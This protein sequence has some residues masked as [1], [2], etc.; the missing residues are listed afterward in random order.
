MAFEFPVIDSAS[1]AAWCEAHLGSRAEAELFRTGHLT[2]V[3]GARLAD[4]REVVVRVRAAAPRVAA[5]TEVQRQLSDS[6]Y[7]CPRPLAGPALLGAYEATAETCITGGTV[8][9][10][11]GRAARPFAAALAEAVRLAPRPEDVPSLAPAPSWTAWNHNQGG[12]WPWPD[13]LNVNLNRVDGPAWID[14]AGRAARR[15][16]QEGQ[17]Q[18][19]IGHGDWITDNLRWNGDRLLVA[20]D[21]DSLIIDTEAVI[22][23]LA[24]AIYLYPARATVAESGE[25]LDAYAVARGRPFSPAE[26][27][28]CWAA[29]VWTM[30]FDAKQAQV[31]GQ[32]GTSLTEGEATERLRLAGIS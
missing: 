30:A 22:A 25:F 6:G 23:G 2:S 15:K 8:L 20:Y 27:Q 21:W 13:D 1:L 31:A 9:P 18:A 4:G 16:L 10:D 3:V 29:G 11:S 17:G 24:A 26:L 19:V 12:L 5:C 7:P 32:P 28:H 14:A